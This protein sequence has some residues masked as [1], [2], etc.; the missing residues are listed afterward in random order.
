MSMGM[1]QIAEI[2]TAVSQVKQVRQQIKVGPAEMRAKVAIA[3][4]DRV[5][6]VVRELK[7]YKQLLDMGALPEEDYE[8]HKARLMDS[9]EPVDDDD[10]DEGEGED[11]EGD[12]GEQR[13]KHAEAFEPEPIDLAP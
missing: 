7:A 13:P 6:A 10:D 9:L 5:E 4:A 12:G 2:A 1:G 11:A 8:T 3:N